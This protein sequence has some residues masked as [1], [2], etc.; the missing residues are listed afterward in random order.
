MIQIWFESHPIFYSFLWVSLQNFLPAVNKCL[1]A[2]GGLHLTLV[3]ELTWGMIQEA[4][5][6]LTTKT[7][8]SSSILSDKK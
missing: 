6:C 7:V 4:D 3:S 8:C 1:L 2:N 5:K